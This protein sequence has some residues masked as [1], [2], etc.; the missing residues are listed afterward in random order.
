MN[1]P[2]LDYIILHIIR[3]FRQERSISG[4]YHLLKGKRSSQTI[5]DGIVFGLSSFFGVFKVMTKDSFMNRVKTLERDGLIFETTPNTYKLSKM[6][7]K[8]LAEQLAKTPIPTSLNGWIYRDETELFWTRLSLLIQTVSYLS[9]DRKSFI[10]LT[11]EVKVQSFIKSILFSIP[12]SKDEIS[13]QLY[14]ELYSVLQ[15]VEHLEATIFLYRLTCYKR[16]GMTIEQCAQLLKLDSTYVSIQFLG[17]IHYFLKRMVEAPEQYPILS[18]LV[19][20]RMKNHCLTSSAAT[21]YK[22]WKEGLSVHEIASVRNLKQSTIE[23]HIVEIA[24]N[25]PSFD[26]SPFLK[27]EDIEQI[28]CKVNELKTHKLKTLYEALHNQYRYFQIRLALAI[29]AREERN[30]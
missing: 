27:Q 11:T 19:Q 18:K 10:P 5:Q 1:R 15:G 26:V 29:C 8:Y 3:T 6:G 21:T 2:F 17:T 7:E 9:Y 30:V 20:D 23:D 28:L 14:K 24:L 13:R 16:T 25:I 12:Y 4:I 22:Y